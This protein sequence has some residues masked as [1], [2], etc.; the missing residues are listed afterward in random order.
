MLT[1]VIIPRMCLLQAKVLI[2]LKLFICYLV[3]FCFIKLL[4][5]FYIKAWVSYHPDLHSPCGLPGL[6]T[7]CVSVSVAG[8]T[9]LYSKPSTRILMKIITKF[10]VLHIGVA[11]KY[12]H[13]ITTKLDM[14]ALF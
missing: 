8:G 9:L 6:T 12:P 7:L 10:N 14:D 13:H 3:D 1:N 11:N 5:K 2:F 4:T